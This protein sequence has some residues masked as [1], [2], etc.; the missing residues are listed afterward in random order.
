MLP[1]TLEEIA[2]I[3]EGTLIG[4]K[5]GTV[6]SVVIDSRKIEVDSLFIAIKGE[7]ADGHDYVRE[8]LQK[9]A[10]GAIV[11]KASGLPGT[12]VVQDTLIALQDLAREVRIRSGI[13]VVAIT[14]STGK[15]TTKDLCSGVL[16]QKF[17]V[18]KTEG[19][20]NNELG[21]PL[22]LLR[23][24][25]HHQVAVLEM[26]MR[27]FGEIDFL[28][29][30]AK[31]DFGIITNIGY[32]HA[33]IL[34][35]QIGIANAK[36]ELLSHIPAN[37]VA[38]LNKEDE[39]LLL[40]LVHKCLGQVIWYGMGDNSDY[41]AKDIIDEGLSGIKFSVES[42]HEET[43]TKVS[44]PLPGKH[45]VVNSLS[46][47]ALA[48][49]M[50]L[51]WQ[52]IVDG[53]GQSKLTSMRFEVLSTELGVQIINDA[54]N[55]NPA[56]MNAALDIL[57]TSNFRGKKIAVLGDMYELGEYSIEG[58]FQVGQRAA[59]AQLDCL[60][61]VGK[62][63]RE[64]AKGAIAT[65]LNLEKV[66]SFENNM[67]AIEFLCQIIKTEDVILIKG[68]RGVKME[69]IVHGLMQTQKL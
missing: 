18:L 2:K 14:G 20:Y 49:E 62:L 55:A 53:L 65:G 56:S 42:R 13:K 58:H 32:T 8:V 5:V 68:S 6:K 33:E 69:E 24:E 17:S 23:L 37:G 44:L 41:Y 25:P 15:T 40:P 57:D 1:L 67:Q 11:S 12:I 66:K 60:V 28:C 9:G 29:S 10:L 43:L 50:E 39:E 36:S 52:E 47:I 48:R 59:K 54:Y 34:G 26:G 30:I 21:L 4:E 51:N 16:A 22:T 19:N 31:P 64:I 27:G 63:A 38:F 61:T 3:V 35:S 7:R 45:N 46:V